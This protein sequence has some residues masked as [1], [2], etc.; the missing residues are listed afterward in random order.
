MP[1]PTTLACERRRSRR[2]AL[3]A[4]AVAPFAVAYLANGRRLADSPAPALACTGAPTTFAFPAG[5]DEP[6]NV[7]PR[8]VSTGGVLETDPR[9]AR[10]QLRTGIMPVG[11]T[12]RSMSSSVELLPAS[13]LLPSTDYEILWSL[14]FGSAPGDS[15]H[16]ASF[17]TGSRIDTT[18]PAIRAVGA[19]AFHP[20]RGEAL[21][22]CHPWQ[23]VALP[24]TV[25]DDSDVI[26]AAWIG[27][28]SGRVDASR[29]PDV[30]DRPSAGGVLL[31][32]PY[33]SRPD[34]DPEKVDPGER[35]RFK[36][37]TLSIMAIDA[38]GNLSDVVAVPSGKRSPA[39][40]WPPAGAVATATSSSAA[41]EA[42]TPSASVS[43]PPPA[44]VSA[45]APP[46]P[47]SAAPPPAERPPAG[48]AC[49]LGPGI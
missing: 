36:R 28:T 32:L 27:D 38:A 15:V 10:Y 44:T 6:L 2:V 22:D 26:V 46:S 8:M 17:R 12:A 35:Y 20:T 34:A 9:G 1:R 31:V 19:P 43:T 29:P 30:Y 5:S 39:P 25:A 48:C 3:L 7:R 11:A 40:S 13:N 23:W 47:A 24:V 45:P 21:T 49:A 4:T 37:R 16:L 33:E 18:P 42:P 14:P 41:A